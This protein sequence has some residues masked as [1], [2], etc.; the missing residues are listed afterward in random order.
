[1]LF[2]VPSEGEG[3][4]SYPR[5][6]QGLDHQDFSKKWAIRGEGFTKLGQL[7]SDD[8]HLLHEAPPP[9]YPPSCLANP[10]PPDFG[11][12]PLEYCPPLSVGFLYLD[13]SFSLL[14]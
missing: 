2:K 5:P 1:M 6:D 14:L 11:P 7:W 10:K 13:H 8:P 12:F 4:A 9:G 3:L